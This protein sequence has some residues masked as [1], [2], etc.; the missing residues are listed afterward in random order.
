M[1]GHITPRTLYSR[2]KTLVPTEQ[3]HGWTP[4]PVRTI[5]KEEKPLGP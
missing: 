4:E 3:D 1:R 2:E 5:W